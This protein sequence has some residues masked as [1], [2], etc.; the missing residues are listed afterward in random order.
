MYKIKLGAAMEIT[1]DSIKP[2]LRFVRY[3]TLTSDSVYYP[4]TPYDARLFYTTD[5]E[6]VIEADG[7]PYTMRKNSLII[8]N[9]GVS[10]HLKTPKVSVSYI[11]INFDFT[12]AQYDKKSPIPPDII[13]CYNRTISIY[14]R[15]W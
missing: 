8:I 14:N 4:S 5:G 15:R 7:K 3:L 2:Y 11:S 13:K 1:F 12:Y 9:S 6:S 10:Y